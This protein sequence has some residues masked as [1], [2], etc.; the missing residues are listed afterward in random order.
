[1]S[2]LPARD[3][4]APGREG[5]HCLAWPRTTACEPIACDPHL[6][7]RNETIGLAAGA[8]PGE[9]IHTQG[10][11]R[12]SG[13]RRCS[14]P[15]FRFDCSS[16]LRKLQDFQAK[17]WPFEASPGNSVLL[18]SRTRK[19]ATQQSRLQLARP[20]ANR[21]VAGCGPWLLYPALSSPPPATPVGAIAH[22]AIRAYLC[23][24]GAEIHADVTLT[25]PPAPRTQRPMI[26]YQPPSEPPDS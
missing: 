1:M 17:V 22:A 10:A 26:R 19:A 3:G 5:V 15:S 4:V 24:S 6:P 12:P 9:W 21:P 8:P 2:R 7:R 16:I 11:S 23:P 18:L 25:L 20:V 14:R 13:R